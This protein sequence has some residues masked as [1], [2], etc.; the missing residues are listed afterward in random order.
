MK[1]NKIFTS[2]MV[3]ARNLPIRVYGEGLGK[4]EIQFA[5]K[6]KTLN[7]ENDN[8]LVEFEPMEYGG[9]YSMEVKFED[10]T[11][12]LE[13]IYIGEVFLFAGQSN[14]QFKLGTSNTPDEL[15]RSNDKLRFF[16]T[17]TVENTD[18]FTPDDGWVVC[19]KDIV[20]K[21]SAVAYLAANEYS[22]KNNVAV[23]VLVCYQGT[24]II[25]SW[26]PCNSFDHLGVDTSDPTRH[27]EASMGAKWNADGFLYSFS[28]SEVIPYSTSTVIWYQGESDSRSNE[29]GEI[30]ADEL[31][32]LINIWRN[33]LRNENLPFVIIQIADY[34][35]CSNPEAWKLV[36][37]AQIDIQSKVPFVKTVISKDVCENDNIHPVT[38]YKVAK[39]VA[40]ALQEINN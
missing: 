35:G 19:E 8:W 38:K 27:S 23:G 17:D 40:E 18:Q 22:L 1:L 36:Q 11:V 10:K 3:F 12:V 2:H 5:G 6:T 21:W 31:A 29:E 37:K 26:V 34:L 33:D 25:E 24:S 28:F 4:V 20:D 14:M 30:Y 32:T 39:R 16:S 15:Y 7:S 9:P 13:D